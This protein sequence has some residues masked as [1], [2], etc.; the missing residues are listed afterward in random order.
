MEEETIYTFKQPKTPMDVAK[1]LSDLMGLV[2]EGSLDMRTAHT[3]GTMSKQFL[4]A[5][6]LGTLDARVQ[7]LEEVLKK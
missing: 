2:L 7:R 1:L 6:E 3:I 5:Y 4:E